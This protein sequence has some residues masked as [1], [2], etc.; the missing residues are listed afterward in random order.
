MTNSNYTLLTCLYHQAL[1]ETDGMLYDF[2]LLL[3]QSTD[4]V[5]NYSCVYFVLFLFYFVVCKFI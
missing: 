5:H 4:Y 1:I 3:N 2:K